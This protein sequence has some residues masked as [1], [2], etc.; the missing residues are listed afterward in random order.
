MKKMNTVDELLVRL[1]RAPSILV[2][3]DRLSASMEHILQTNYDCNVDST[4]SGHEAIGMMTVK[5]YDLV[6]LDLGLLNGTGSTVVK[7]TQQL[8]PDTPVVALLSEQML[9]F[10]EIM[11]SV[12]SLMLLSQ[13]ATLEIV[14]H[15]FKVFK[16][17]PRTKEIAIH[18]RHLAEDDESSNHLVEV[19]SS[20]P[21][22]GQ[23]G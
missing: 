4:S 23:V 14:R 9:D 5:K 18:C 3:E 16:I 19:S 8:C 22:V 10:N 6:Y 2:V 21:M 11:A 12:D 20:M 17:K 15:L 1:F 13:P 7:S